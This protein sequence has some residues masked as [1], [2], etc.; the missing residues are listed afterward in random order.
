MTVYFHGSFGFNRH[1][2]AGVL[3]GGLKKPE[4]SADELAAPFGY[5]APFTARYRSWLHKSGL[6]ELRTPIR[7]TPMGEVVW[8]HD[9]E[10]NYI[11]TQWF[12]HHELCSDPTRNETWHF[13]INEFL[14]SNS[15][16][17]RGDLEVGLAKK[18]M[19]HSEK[20]FSPQ[21]RMTKTIALKLTECYTL[22][23]ALGPL[24][25]LA[26]EGE[27]H[28]RYEKPTVLGP[29]KTASELEDEFLKYKGLG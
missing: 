13:F 26:N 21:S 16:F 24:G 15:I 7:L 11:I 9:R 8:K 25:L 28:Y 10:L 6:S 29:W 4:A 2:M 17:S 23:D 5:R 3:A 20:H 18:L 22:P 19:P 12:M 1:N 14:P 27:T